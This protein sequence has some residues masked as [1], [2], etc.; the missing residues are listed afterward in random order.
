MLTWRG[1]HIVK[2]RAAIVELLAQDDSAVGGSGAALVGEPRAITHPVK[3]YEKGDLPLEF[4]TTR[5]WFINILDH[6]K[7][8]L[9]QGDK[10]SWFPSYMKARYDNWVEGLQY[11]WCISRQRFFG[12]PFPVW[13]PIDSYGE[14][15]YDTPIFA[16]SDQLPIDPLV[17]VPTGYTSDQRKK[18]GGFTADPDV[19]DTWATSSMTPQIVSHWSK[20]DT[21]H[22]K[23]FPMDV[24]PQSHE[25]IRTWAF[26]T[27]VKAWMHQNEIPWKNVVIS[28][29]IL[30]PD[31]K[32]MSKSKGN[33]V[34]PT[35]L[36]EKY[37][38]DAVRYWA[39]R[40]RLGVDTAYDEKVF[41]NGQKLATKLFNVSRFVHM[42]IAQLEDDGLATDWA[43]IHIEL[44]T[45][46]VNKLETLVREVTAAFEVFDYAQA[47]HLAEREF[48]SFCDSYVELVKAR[49]YAGESE[50]ERISAV[51]ALECAIHVFLRLFAPAM[52]YITEEVWSWHFREKRGSGESIHRTQWPTV[53]EFASLKK[54][55]APEAMEFASGN[56]ILYS[57]REIFSKE[58]S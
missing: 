33:V 26:Y 31:R 16:S 4:I 52:P 6:Q 47:L 8:L 54:S 22:A 27:I 41:S 35:H 12:V 24:R 25:I 18:P 3:F 2:A 57:P 46:L 43:Q 19:M 58:N 28:G 37:S 56:T 15:R 11:D 49:A 32:K 7:S 45:V 44:D 10:I 13:Y 40:A 5:Q 17:D 53:A 21:R 42:Q 30:D 36:L 38:S 51:S 34:T 1:W 9:A 48:W 29:W 14:I 50:R 23:L 20:N 39:S 55:S